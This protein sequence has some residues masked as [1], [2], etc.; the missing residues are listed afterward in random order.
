MSVRLN[1]LENGIRVVTHEMSHL[2]TVSLGVWVNVGARFES[3]HQHGISHFLEHM[4]FK[5]TPSRTARQIAEG[6]ESV[7]GDINAATSLD[8]TCYYARI[9]KNDAPLAIDIIGDI[10]Q[11]PL[12]DKLEL[13]REK[14][15]VLQE[16]AAAD[17]SPDDIVYDLAHE[18]AYPEQS[19]GRTILGTEKSVASFS[20]EKLKAY[21]DQHYT[22]GNIV[23]GAAGALEHDQIMENVQS[24]LGSMNGT[25]TAISKPARYHGGMRKSKKPFEQTHVII[26]FEGVSYLHEDYYAAQVLSVLL[27]AGMSSRLF[28]EARERRGLCYAIYSFSWGMSDTGMFGI[29]AATGPDQVP[30]LVGVIVQQLK[31]LAEK[32][33]TEEELSR[34]KAQLKAGLL[35][36]LES[37]T[38]RVEQIARQ[39]LAFDRTLEIDELIQKVDDVSPEKIKDLV[40]M[41]ITNSIP[42]CSG[43]GSFGQFRNYDWLID[44]FQS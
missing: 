4:A 43:V 30:E 18:A 27:G 14:D 21:M 19:I 8:T 20:A 7:G 10:L 16:I 12:F 25:Q 36:S 6:I 33:P 31:E 2:E 13:H 5:G 38:A 37:T 28:Q 1:Q 40:K 17:D 23:V 32:G 44:Q 26:A 9:L 3:L 11:N 34:S 29:H 39:V 24:V 41:I 35:M 15:V 42:T 22:A